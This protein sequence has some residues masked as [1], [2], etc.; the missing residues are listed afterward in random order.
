MSSAPGLRPEAQPEGSRGW[1]GRMYS[2]NLRSSRKYVGSF[3]A[4]SLDFEAVFD[5]LK[6]TFGHAPLLAGL[7]FPC[8]CSI[9]NKEW[10]GYKGGVYG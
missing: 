8:V 9:L 2:T 1:C 4:I 5:G 7:T 3:A 10:W 6:Q